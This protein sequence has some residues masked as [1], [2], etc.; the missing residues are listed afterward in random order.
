VAP[1]DGIHQHVVFK[2]AALLLGMEKA[3]NINYIA[4]NV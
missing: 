4:A 1:N 3:V 2:R